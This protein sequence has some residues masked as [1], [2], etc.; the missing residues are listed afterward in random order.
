[1]ILRQTLAALVAILVM[2]TATSFA[3]AQGNQ[4]YES[5][6]CSQWK[7]NSDGTWNTGPNGRLDGMVFPNSVHLAIS[8]EVINGVD[9]AAMLANKCGTH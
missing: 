2:F 9:L 3:L 7:E 6:D 4:L 1:M 8:H 5:I